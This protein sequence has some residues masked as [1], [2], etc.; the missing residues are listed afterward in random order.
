MHRNSRL[1]FEKRAQSLFQ[2]GMRVLE[3]GPDGA[4]GTYER[5]AGGPDITWDTVDLAK[6][7]QGAP[8]TYLAEDEY[9][10]PVPDDQYDIVVSG[11]VIEHVKKV[12][13]WVHELARVTK[14]GGRVITI[15]PLNWPYHEAPVDCWRIYPDGFRALYEDAGLEVETCLF[16]SLDDGREGGPGKVEMLKR[17]ARLLARRATGR[18]YWPLGAFK[19]EYAVDTVAIGRKPA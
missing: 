11:Q 3:I 10:F 17:E 5:C 2:P 19:G 12:W 18:P 14:P 4:P 16:E 6:F 15:A 9:H 7:N 8:L 13:V 1:L